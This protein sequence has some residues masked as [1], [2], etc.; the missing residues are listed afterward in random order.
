[1]ATG[2]TLKNTKAIY[3]AVIGF[4]APGAAYLI[5]VAD[6]GVSGK[7]WLI[8]ALICLG[9]GLALGGGVQQIENKPKDPAT[10]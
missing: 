9:G 8:A 3:A 4:V 7:E 1:M 6:D 5:G 10:P 2:D